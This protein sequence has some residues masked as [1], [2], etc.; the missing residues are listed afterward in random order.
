[1]SFI[2]EALRKSEKKHEETVVPNLHTVHGTSRPVLKKRPMWPYWLVAVL[3]LNAGILLW[4]LAPWEDQP[5]LPPIVK[6]VDGP[7]EVPLVAVPPLAQPLSPVPADEPIPAPPETLAVEPPPVVESVKEPLV[8][9]T[10]APPVVEVGASAE[11]IVEDI[12]ALVETE[13]LSSS[14]EDSWDGERSI[15]AFSELP[16]EVQSRLPE[17]HVSV[18]AY[19]ID[20]ASR[21]VRVNNRILREGGYLDVGLLLEEITPSGMVFFFEGYRFQ[22]PKQ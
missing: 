10:P 4:F 16:Y 15:H 11:S 1:M 5:A 3:L 6:A 18:H 8:V 7:N 17:I 19:S 22:V 21:L 20:A 12:P 13:T 2:L 9:A 14:S